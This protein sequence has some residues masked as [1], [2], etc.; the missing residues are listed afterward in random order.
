MRCA[1]LLLG[2]AALAGCNNPIDQK[3]G[4]ERSSLFGSAPAIPDP[5]P[6]DARVALSGML[7]YMG[8]P[9]MLTWP[10]GTPTNCQD[11]QMDQS[12]VRACEV[13]VVVTRVL[14]QGHAPQSLKAVTVERDIFNIA[15]KRA[16]SYDQPD[17]IPA[18]EGQGVWVVAKSPATGGPR[19]NLSYQA[20]ETI[21]LT[22][23]NL[24]Q[25]GVRNHGGLM[26]GFVTVQNGEV[27]GWPLEYN[28]MLEVFNERP[29]SG[30]YLLSLMPRTCTSPEVSDQ[31]VA[32]R[33][34]DQEAARQAEYQAVR[35]KKAAEVAAAE[36]R[37]AERRRLESIGVHVY[38]CYF[39]IKQC[40]EAAA[41]ARKYPADANAK[42]KKEGGNP[43]NPP[44]TAAV[45]AKARANRTTPAGLDAMA[46]NAAMRAY[47]KA[48][49][50]G[51]TEV[52]LR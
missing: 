43:E 2:L 46:R 26:G 52:P 38:N 18:S 30:S 47:Y 13:C 27:S 23:A 34:A 3:T 32:Q 6:Q 35:D 1:A 7:D 25:L 10:A 4:S 39:N 31:A 50:R 20:K 48:Q 9:T 37:Q 12:K 36:A 5:S 33:L 51:A 24:E 15:F 44:W 28:K 8:G 42:L 11:G 41:D 29:N 45:Q 16:I 14:T 49:A 19:P 17:V 40:D 21:T 22:V